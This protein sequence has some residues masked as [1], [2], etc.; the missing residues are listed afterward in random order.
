MQ[1]FSVVEC[2]E[3]A[4]YLDEDV[5][6]LLLLDVGFSLLVITDFLENIAVVSVLHDEA[7]R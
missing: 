5:P 7:Q 6:D 3:S 4:D 1:N 2:P